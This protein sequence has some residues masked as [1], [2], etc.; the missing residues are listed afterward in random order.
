ML[1]YSACSARQPGVAGLCRTSCSI[2]R[3]RTQPLPAMLTC[4]YIVKHNDSAS[5]RAA[6]AAFL[7]SRASQKSAVCR[8]SRGPR[9]KVENREGPARRW[10]FPYVP[11]P[12]PV[13]AE[14]RPS[15]LARLQDVRHR[16]GSITGQAMHSAI[17]CLP[18]SRYSWPS[19]DHGSPDLHDNSVTPKDLPTCRPCHPCRPPSAYSHSAHSRIPGRTC[20]I[21]ILPRCAAQDQGNKDAQTL[22][23]CYSDPR[24]Q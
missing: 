13:T 8:P 16:I 4:W 15:R 19:S 17:R 7:C 21:F 24:T 3:P 23:A 9:V 10:R 22:H 6:R 1:Q 12:R 20:R 11:V 18:S 2:T 5:L 14:H